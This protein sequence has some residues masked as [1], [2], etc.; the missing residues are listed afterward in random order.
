VASIGPSVTVHVDV[1]A[2]IRWFGISLTLVLMSWS[3]TGE[4]AAAVLRM[5]MDE[6]LPFLHSV[7]NS[8]GVANSTPRLAPTVSDLTDATAAEQGARN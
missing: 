4:H 8:G 2:C 3:P 7:G 5:V 6:E 1:A